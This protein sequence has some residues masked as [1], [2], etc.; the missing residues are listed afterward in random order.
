MMRELL[1]FSI[2]KGFR[3]DNPVEHIKTMTTPPR[4]RY[5][6]D[7]ELRRI[8][9]HAA[10]PSGKRSRSGEMMAAIID[11]AYLTGQRL[12]D[13][14]ALTW[15]QF[16]SKGITFETNKTGAKIMIVWTPKLQ[17]L[18]KKL[19]ALKTNDYYVLAQSDGSRL[20]KSSISRYWFNA[21]I[22][23]RVDNAH[24]HDIRAK[25]ITDKE[26]KEGLAAAQHMGGHTTQ[27]QTSI[28]VRQFKHRTISAT[29]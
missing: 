26:E 4:T 17:E 16:T 29:R 15:D 3:E 22:K 21:C 11:M 10:T 23:A 19:I 12:G 8:K 6:T 25:A 20:K 13:L 18:K 2:E 9:F 5:I 24:F 14:E 7:S 27:Q 1:R 28:Y